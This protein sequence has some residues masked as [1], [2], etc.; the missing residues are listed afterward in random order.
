MSNGD[1]LPAFI[2]FDYADDQS[3][4]WSFDITDLAIVGTYSIRLIGTAEGLY[5]NSDH[6]WELNIE[7]PNSA[8]TNDVLTL[9]TSIDDFT[10]TLL[11]DGSS[12]P[13]TKTPSATSSLDGCEIVWT[14]SHN[15][16]PAVDAAV[17]INPES[18]A[19]KVDTS[20]LTLDGESVEFTVR[21]QTGPMVEFQFT[22]DFVTDCW[23]TTLTAPNFSQSAFSV[24]LWGQLTIDFEPMDDSVGTCG[25][26]EYTLMLVDSGSTPAGVVFGVVTTGYVAMDNINSSMVLQLDDLSWI[27]SWDLYLVG[28][29]GIYNSID[30]A[31]QIQLEVVNPCISA[32]LV[33]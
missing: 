19:F 8:C 18:G 4:S 3:L 21:A 30:S 25:A 16:S 15:G 27:G 13:V 2:N 9:V 10:Y 32:V 31:T 17:S 20:D 24:D 33:D 29:V 1:P 23:S 26:Y 5:S 22:V 12:V 7:D 14:M 28:K 11:S 6:I